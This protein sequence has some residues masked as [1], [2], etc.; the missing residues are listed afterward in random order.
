MSMRIARLGAMVLAVLMVVPAAAVAERPIPDQY[1]VVLKD[2]AAQGAAVADHRRGAGARVLQTYGSAVKGYTAKLSAQGL[3]TV[4]ADPRV[5]FVTQDV[6]G[7]PF[8]GKPAPAP[9]APANGLP[10]GVDRIDGDLSSALSGDGAGAVSGTVAIAD[11]GIDRMHPDLNVDTTP[12]NSVNCLDPANTWNDKTP[13]DQQGHGTHVAGI[14]GADDDRSG[15]VGVAPGVR[16]I[17]VRNGDAAGGSTLSAQVCS[18]DWVT[19][20]AARLGIK[21]ANASW[22]GL[23][24]PDDASCATTLKVL[25][26]ALCRSRDAGVLWAFGVGNKAGGDD[27]KGVAGAA[28]D[29]VLAVTGVADANGRPGGGGAITCTSNEVDD[30]YYYASLYSTIDAHHTVA[31]PAVC[32]YSTFKGATY[33]VMSGTSMASPHAAGVAMLCIASGEC[34]HA[35]PLG[36]PSV[37]FTP[38]EIITKLRADAEAYNR[39]NPAFGFN[40]DPLRPVTGRYYGFLLRAA[41]Y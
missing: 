21:V 8:A 6:H 35:D 38:Q 14:V 34:A 10:T 15:I 17:S 1:I 29:E 37:A 7:F 3:A 20:N 23:E 39:A 19:N 24:R 11:T 13:W 25:H 22:A 41:E 12:G 16:L 40:G 32:I 30:R 31:A 5:A 26:Q 36:G 4:K 2:G 27:F 9:T 33:K 18:V 28:Y